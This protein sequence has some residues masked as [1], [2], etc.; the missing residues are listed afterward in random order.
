M[1]HVRR[2]CGEH[3]CHSAGTVFSETT[4]GSGSRPCERRS[5]GWCRGGCQWAA[6]ESEF[7]LSSRTV[8][9][10]QTTGRNRPSG[11]PLRRFVF[12]ALVGPSHHHHTTWSED[13]DLPLPS[14]VVR[15]LPSVNCGG[16][17]CSFGL[18]SVAAVSSLMSAAA[19][20]SRNIA[21]GVQASAGSLKA[22]TPTLNIKEGRP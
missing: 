2:P 14:A 17:A 6:A 18:H 5:R 3:S 22:D 12:P 20:L 9:S 19:R 13:G 21:V 8:R 10:L 7:A 15:R 4:T 11:Y 16:A 1:A